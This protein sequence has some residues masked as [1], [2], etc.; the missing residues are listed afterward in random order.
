MDGMN[1]PDP[2]REIAPTILEGPAPTIL[3][4]GAIM[5]LDGRDSTFDAFAHGQSR[6]LPAATSLAGQVID[7]HTLAEPIR[8]LSAEADLWKVTHTETG[9]ARV[10]KHF[11]WGVSPKGDVTEALAATE[12][13]HIVRVFAR[14]IHDGRHYEI[15]EYV[16][17]GSLADVLKRGEL[18]A[19][20]TNDVAAQLA[21]GIQELHQLDILHRDIKPSNILVRALEPLELLITDFGISSVADVSLHLTSA[22]RTASYSAPE[23]L[24]G[25]VTRGSDWWSAGVVILEVATGRHPFSGLS[26]QAINF[27]LV[28]RGIPIPDGLSDDLRLLLRGLLAR[29]YRQRWGY[30][31]LRGWLDGRRDMAVAGDAAP[32]E[33]EPRPSPGVTRAHTPRSYKFQGADYTTPE[34][35]S[36]ALA[37]SWTEGVK[38]FGRGFITDWVKMQIFDQTMASLLVDVSLDKDLT[39]DERLSVALLVLNPDLPLIYKGE[40]IVPQWMAAHAEQA[41]SLMRGTLGQW[42]ADLRKDRW[43]LDL[44]HQRRRLW[45]EVREMAIPVNEELLKALVISDM[46]SVIET[47]TEHRKKFA[48]AKDEKL[49]NILAKKDLTPGEAVAILAADRGCFLTAEEIEEAE[50][51]QQIEEISSRFMHRKIAFNRGAVASAM[52]MNPDEAIRLAKERMGMYVGA[53][54]AALQRLFDK[55]DT[56]THREAAAFLAADAG[57]LLTAE[58]V[59]RERERKNRE[60]LIARLKL[61]QF[62][63]D[64]DVVDQVLDNRDLLPELLRKRHAQYVRARRE[65]PLLREVFAKAKPDFEEGL[66][67]AA[68]HPRYFESSAQAVVGV[69]LAAWNGF[70]LAL[71]RSPW[72]SFAMITAVCVAGHWL[73]ESIIWG[74]LLGA[75]GLLL[76]VLWYLSHYYQE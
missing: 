36:L 13:R 57:Q 30:E 16:A 54:H 14:G 62:D 39:A 24:T 68:A 52:A 35:L 75:M 22:S 38:H 60:E 25:V 12:L 17:N 49:R 6:P 44:Q 61:E 1:T 69:P 67:L 10:L 42:L 28:T 66:L 31:E 41:A 55:R 4:E 48:S 74:I 5:M 3:E 72:T 2:E 50:K 47:A 33:P 63:L 21:E 76:W 19:T 53:S 29:D 37:A 56:L 20:R 51:R 32:Q 65:Y 43:L 58:R 70:R 7:G 15:Q 26:E 27:Q 71:V 18:D 40:W 8:V 64:W 73:Y 11:R 59:E 45:G 9:E 34:E 23:A 46:A